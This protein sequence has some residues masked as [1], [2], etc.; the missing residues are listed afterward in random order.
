MKGERI[1]NV[2][3]MDGYD[4]GRAREIGERR[5]VRFAAALALSFPPRD[6][7]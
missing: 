3:R 6:T 2:K 7:H 4:A 1:N 5:Y